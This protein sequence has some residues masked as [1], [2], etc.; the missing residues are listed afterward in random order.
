MQQN[1][2]VKDIKLNI[3]DKKITILFDNNQ[4]YH[5]PAEYLRVYSPSTKVREHN[6]KSSKLIYG[7]KHI[8]IMNIELVG[9][10]ALKISFD[11]MHDSGIY[12][13]EL[14]YDLGK[15]LNTYWDVYLK[16]L[17]KENKSR[18]P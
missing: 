14:L 18:N 7:R 5:Y 11:D 3:I 4:I 1:R 12:S 17:K 8:G 13:W 15:N 6:N 2:N 16:R 10:Y 9:N